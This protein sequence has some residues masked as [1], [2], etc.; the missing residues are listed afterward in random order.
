MSLYPDSMY[1]FPNVSAYDSDLREVLAMLR[2]VT[3]KMKDFEAI[4]KITNA[5]AWD[6]T[7]Q[8]KPWTI[9]SDNNIG[10]ISVRPVP[11]GIEITNTDYWGL[12]ADYDILITNLSERISTLENEVGNENSGLIKDVADLQAQSVEQLRGRKI[13]ILTDSYGVI[14]DNY[15][16]QMVTM[17]PALVLNDNL[18]VFAY[19]ARG[20]IGDTAGLG[21][22]A[23]WYTAF[24]TSGDINTVPDPETI[25]DFYIVGGSND[26]G[27]SWNDIRTNALALLSAIQTKFTN[28]R[29]SVAC[30]AYTKAVAGGVLMPE[31]IENYNTLG[32]LGYR[33]IGNAYSW[34][35]YPGLVTDNVHPNAAGSRMIASGLLRA[36][37]GL[38]TNDVFT[39][40]NV[41]IN[42]IT[43][44][45]GTMH[46]VD[47]YEFSN[48]TSNYLVFERI[49]YTGS[50]TLYGDGS[51][52]ELGTL[53][54]TKFMYGAIDG[55]YMDHTF[56]YIDAGH[57]EPCDI[58][59]YNGK[60]YYRMF[61]D[62]SIPNFNT[63][64]TTS[65][66]ELA[67]IKIEMPAM[68]F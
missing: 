40:R 58:K 57:V 34:I 67:S 44:A 43:P 46:R 4:N 51:W 7:K 26:K 33:V 32:R 14:T 54:S 18:Y 22:D 37:F 11:A 13:V 2:G 59:L 10:Y 5:G 64:F 60:L 29:V 39:N 30:C 56:A 55:L 35:H 41:P 23:T 3:H 1:D 28:A 49:R 61:N 20:F 6:I 19:G 27:E 45:F 16:Q 38:D 9:V 12:V 68:F 31:L 66:L 8:Y 24:V 53:T 17:C 65:M 42:N 21:A 15:V 47:G 63:G 25:T 52:H 36:I 62:T 50:F 48:G